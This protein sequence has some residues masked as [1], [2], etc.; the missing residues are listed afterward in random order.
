MH[1]DDKWDKRR[2]KQENISTLST[3]H[4]N[5]L[6]QSTITFVFT[7]SYIRTVPL[8]VTKVYFSFKWAFA[9]K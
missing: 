1:L 4:T 2:P 5:I 6:E 8:L 9:S 7:S 3:A